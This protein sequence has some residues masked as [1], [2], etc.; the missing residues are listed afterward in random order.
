MVLGKAVDEGKEQN[1]NIDIEI[2]ITGRAFY[3]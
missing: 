1:Y 2:L 3:E